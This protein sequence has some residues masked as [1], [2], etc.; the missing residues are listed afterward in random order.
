MQEWQQVDNR[1]RLK[2]WTDLF[3]TEEFTC[4]TQCFLVLQEKI[5]VLKFL[6]WNEKFWALLYRNLSSTFL[7]MQQSSFGDGKQSIQYETSDPMSQKHKIKIVKKNLQFE[8]QTRFKNRNQSTLKITYTNTQSLTH[9]STAEDRIL[10]YI[11]IYV[12]SS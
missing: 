3:L 5:R 2:Y 8:I 1:K 6:I 10:L 11:Y 12:F 7:C 9:K 4:K